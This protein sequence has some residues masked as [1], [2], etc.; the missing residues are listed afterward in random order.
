MLLG[1]RLVVPAGSVKKV[2]EMRVQ[3]GDAVLVALA[4]RDRERFAGR[5][6]SGVITDSK[7]IRATKCYQRL[8]IAT[9][10]RVIVGVYVGIVLGI[11][12]LL[13]KANSVGDAIATLAAAAVFLSLLRWVQRRV[14]RRF[15]RAT[16]NAAKVVDAFGERLRSGADPHAAAADLVGAVN[17]TLQPTAFG[18]WT[19]VDSR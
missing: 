13:P 8:D 7:L 11:G 1:A 18:I 10:P 17:Q 3:R 15:D 6:K 12:A 9:E 4:F 19:P 16:Y 5:L 14:D 2:R